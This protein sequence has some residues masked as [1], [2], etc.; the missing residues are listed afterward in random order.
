MDKSDFTEMGG[1]FELAVDGIVISISDQVM[2]DEVVQLAE[3]VLQVYSQRVE[4]VA[5]HI[6]RDEWIAEAYG[7]SKEEVLKKLGKPMVLL[8]K[9]GGRLSYCENRI[10]DDHIIDVEFGGALEEFYEVGI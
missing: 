1:F 4:A 6:A 8:N 5:E 10:D 2:C 3:K 9:N 7:F